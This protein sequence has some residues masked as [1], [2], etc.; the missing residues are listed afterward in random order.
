MKKRIV[1]IDADIDLFQITQQNQQEIQWD[2]DTITMTCDTQNARIV[3]DAQVAGIMA[4]VSADDYILCLSGADNFRK[5]N[6]P[7]YKANRKETRKPMGYKELKQHAIDNHPH[8]IYNTLE[9][10]D[11]MGIMSTLNKNPEIE[12]VIHSD[13]KDMFTI[14]GLIWDRKIGKV[15]KTSEL[16][17]D[18]FLYKQILTGDVTDGYSGCPTIGKLKAA[19]ALNG[20]TSSDQMRSEVLKL[21]VK[22]YKFPELAKEKMLEQARQ[23][24]ILR[25]TDYN[26]KTKEV[27]LWNPWKEEDS[28]NNENRTKI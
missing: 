3:F 17:A 15:T 22:Y 7:T 2:E 6:F 26:F 23:A 11:V 1:L 27:I 14:P 20:C 28:G 13:D 12:Y 18:R 10:D 21:Y 8:K 19:T 25:S 9:A 16:E 24:R 5:T 4:K